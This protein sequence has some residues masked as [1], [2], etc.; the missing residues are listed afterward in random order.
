MSRT[1]PAYTFVFFVALLATAL[2]LGGALAHAFELL[3]KI[4][5]SREEYFIVQKV[6]RGWAQ[7][8]YVLA[9]QLAAMIAL[10]VMSRSEPAVFWPVVLALA[11][12]AGAQVVFWTTT[13]PANVAT[14]NWTEI[15]ENWQALRDQWEYSHAAGAVFQLLAMCFLFV[16]ALARGR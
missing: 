2:A 7:L 15:P 11:C 1:G 5:L 4:D 10:A 6:Y 14:A 8:A 16:A 13:F 12:F 9:V 3:N